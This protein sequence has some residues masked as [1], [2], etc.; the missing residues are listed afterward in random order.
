[1][2]GLSD[3]DAD[4]ARNLEI[5]KGQEWLDVP[6][7]YSNQRRAILAIDKGPSGNQAFEAA[8]SS[9]EQMR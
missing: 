9:W 6:M 2:V 4:R 8:F 7:V 3:V 1:L 5:L